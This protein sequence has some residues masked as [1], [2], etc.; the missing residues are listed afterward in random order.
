MLGQRHVE[1][2]PLQLYDWCL[3]WIESPFVSL[4]QLIVFCFNALQFVTL[5][6]RRGE[7]C[8]GVYL[9]VF[10]WQDETN[11]TKLYFA[12]GLHRLIYRW[13]RLADPL[14]SLPCSF[15][16]SVV[17]KCVSP[18]CLDLSTGP[19][20]TFSFN[21]N[22]GESVYYQNIVSD[23]QLRFHWQKKNLPTQRCNLPTRGPLPC[24]AA[25]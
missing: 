3:L 10:G 1:T 11:S 6:M 23:L 2:G 21:C 9:F 17:D 20:L 15:D 25:S 8:E 14:L 4:L 19:F 13:N 18:I 5:W 22:L 7:K 12:R 16:Q 24:L